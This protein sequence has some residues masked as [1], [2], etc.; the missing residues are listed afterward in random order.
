MLK[1][2]FHTVLGRTENQ[3]S[4]IGTN[5]LIV[6]KKYHII[7][8]FVANAMLVIIIKFKININYISTKNISHV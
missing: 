2:V 4:G 8:R 1:V 5:L 6:L 7:S 3:T